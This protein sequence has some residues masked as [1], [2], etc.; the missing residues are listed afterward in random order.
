MSLLTKNTNSE[1]GFLSAKHSIVY[2]FV[3]KV[4]YVDYI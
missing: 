3:P 4:I 1:G 2:A